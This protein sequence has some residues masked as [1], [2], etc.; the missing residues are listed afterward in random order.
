MLYYI[1]LVMLYYQFRY[2]ETGETL[3][4]RQKTANSV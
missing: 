4:L 1:I 3:N 2:P